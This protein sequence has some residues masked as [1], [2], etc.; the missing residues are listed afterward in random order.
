MPI[1][2]RYKLFRTRL[3]L[4]P[5][6]YIA[7][8]HEVPAYDMDGIIGR[9]LEKGS[10][11]TRTDI[12]AVLNSFFE[13]VG[14][15]TA[16]G[17]VIKTKLFRTNFS[18]SGLFDGVKDMFD[19][20]RHTLK[21]NINMGEVF[22]EALTKVQMEKVVPLDVVPHILQVIDNASGSVNDTVASGGIVEIT[23][24][25][26]R[27]RGDS[28][29]NGVYFV[30][31]DGAKHEV[32]TIVENKPSRLFVVLPTLVA[33]QYALQITTQYNKGNRLSD[34]PKTGIFS[35]FLTVV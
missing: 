11:V 13:T 5:E 20:N 4:K 31:A 35:E 14:T 9:M 26:I 27:I 33:G 24:N 23:G 30:A 32:V 29:D 1:Q 2:I 28:A 16:E 6:N 25:H 18:I 17:Y 12:L 21:V 19:K 7:R 15:L 34:V 10:T 8:T 3:T 22:R